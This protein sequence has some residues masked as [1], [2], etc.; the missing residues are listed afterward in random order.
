VIEKLEKINRKYSIH[1]GYQNHSGTRVGGPVWDLYW[2]VKDCD[3]A[4]MGVQYDIRH[5]VCE[6]G[7][8]WP[9]GMKLLS[10]WIRTLDVKDFLWKKVES[11]WKITNVPLGEG[12]VDLDA[13]LKHYIA[14]ELSGPVSIHYEYDLGGAESGKTNPSMG[15]NEITGFLKRDLLYLHSKYR[16]SGLE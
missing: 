11:N 16:Q 9:V 5:A 7:A 13:W 6:G 14:L 2:L 1:G 15:L 12:M 8:S 3:P 4:F 10:P